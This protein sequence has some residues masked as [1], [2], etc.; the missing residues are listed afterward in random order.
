MTTVDIRAAINNEL[1]SFT[2]DML[3]QVAEYMKSLR[4]ERHS[5]KSTTIT[6]LVASLF[7]GHSISLTDDELD[8]M[9]EAYL[10]EKYL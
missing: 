1:N 7:T 2:P 8:H 3:L 5:S 6:P 4:E 9:K 10:K